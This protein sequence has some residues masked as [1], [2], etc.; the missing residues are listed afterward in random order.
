V[1]VAVL[2]TIGLV[3][4]HAT[5]ALALAFALAVAMQAGMP[6]LG[7][8]LQHN[9]DV[10]FM[11]K[12]LPVFLA[13]GLVHSLRHRIVLTWPGALIALAVSVAVI[14]R[15]ETWGPQLCAPLITYA[16][17]WV[18]AA[19]PSPALLRRHDISYGIYIYAFP[20]QQLLVMV[21][22]HRWGV[23][24]YDVLAAL[25]TIPFALASWLLVE[26]PVMERARRATAGH[27][28]PP[29]GT[30]GRAPEAEPA[31]A[32]VP[33]LP[34]THDAVVPDPGPTAK[35]VPTA[36]GVG[37]APVKDDAVV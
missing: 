17:L 15:N 4:R 26:R 11:A 32:P 8:Y 29:A 3:R 18:G 10:G 25:A 28:R 19:M 20:V 30:P 5:W 13:G 14:A 31:P 35:A 7:P 33:Q 24:V 34:A 16:I 27:G 22:A 1:V 2:G 9:G 6:V 12:L 23:A 36:A 37:P 21:G